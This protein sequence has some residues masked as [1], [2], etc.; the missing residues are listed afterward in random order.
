M[1]WSWGRSWG[2]ERPSV[3]K[4]GLMALGWEAA[5][6]KDTVDLPQVN[7]DGSWA[8]SGQSNNSFYSTGFL[9]ANPWRPRGANGLP[10]VT[11]PWLLSSPCWLTW[12]CPHLCIAPLHEIVFKIPT[13]SVSCQNSDWQSEAEPGVS[14]KAFG[15]PYRNP[16]APLMRSSPS[17]TIGHGDTYSGTTG[18][19]CLLARIS[20][21]LR[22][23]C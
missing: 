15:S 6:M 14:Q 10:L 21:L 20:F 4:Q 8:D 17:V 19:Q 18:P 9:H 5:S 2:R 3:G 16:Q 11:S 1:P 22:I 12:S 23:T 13:A 7:S